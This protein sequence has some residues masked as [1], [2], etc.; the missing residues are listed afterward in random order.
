MIKGLI[1]GCL[2]VLGLFLT[3]SEKVAASGMGDAGQ[4]AA[5]HQN[6]SMLRV[7]QKDV[8]VKLAK[9]KLTFK[10]LLVQRRRNLFTID[11]VCRVSSCRV[12]LKNW[13]EWRL[14]F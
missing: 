2:G 4:V 9:S 1:E 6:M 7:T 13:W 8:A 14:N 12:R 10:T 5:V 3:Q 11:V